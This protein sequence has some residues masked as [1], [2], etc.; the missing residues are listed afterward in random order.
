MK[1]DDIFE[2]ITD[3]DDNL[4]A[5]ALITED[6][7]IARPAYKPLWKTA[8]PIAAC[9]AA[10]V[11]AGVFGARYF[12][13]TELSKI[14]ESSPTE[15]STASSIVLRY[16]DEAKY[17]VD[18][19]IAENT[20]KLTWEYNDSA[21]YDNSSIFAESYEEL[22]KQSDL[23]LS[24]IFIDDTRQTQDPEKNHITGSEPSE[25]YNY[26]R[27]ESVIKGSA[28]LG[29]NVL[30]R[31]KTS[32][33][34]GNGDVYINFSG[35]RLSP[36][37]KGD[38]WI[39][40][41]KKNGEFYEPVN[42]PQ[43][44]YPLSDSTNIT[45]G[46]EGYDEYFTLKNAAPAR[47]EIYNKL[48]TLLSSMIQRIDI[49]ED[50]SET[51]FTMS[52]C[53][54]VFYASKGGIYAAAPSSYGIDRTC[55]METL[56][57]L[58]LY[59]ADINEDG[60]RELC[61]VVNAN[62]AQSIV[63]NQ[64][65]IIE[66]ES[67][68]Y[69]SSKT[70]RILGNKESDYTLE[71]NDGKLYAVKR[72]FQPIWESDPPEEISREQLTFD[73]ITQ[74]Q[75]DAPE[76]IAVPSDGSETKFTLDDGSNIEYAVSKS[77]V[78]ADGKRIIEGE[79]NNLFLAKL[80]KSGA[81]LI[82]A[83]V[84]RNGAGTVEILAD[85]LYRLTG[86]PHDVYETE[87]KS[88][89]LELKDNE[90]NLVTKTSSFDTVSINEEPI[91]L[92]TLNAMTPVSPTE[93][94]D[95]IKLGGGTFA[96]EEYPE[97]MFTCT[98]DSG[99]I[100][101]NVT[102]T[103]P[104]KSV[105]GAGPG[106]GNNALFLKDLNGDG[107]RELCVCGSIGSGIIHP[108]ITVFDAANNEF[109]FKNGAG[110]SD[111]YWREISLEMKNGELYFVTRDYNDNSE[112][113]R[114]L[115][116][117]EDL[118]ISTPKPKYE[119]LCLDIERQ[120]TLDDFPGIFEV[121]HIYNENSTVITLSARSSEYDR[122]FL[123][124]RAYLYD[125]NGDGK[126]ELCM[127]TSYANVPC[128]EVWGLREDGGYGEKIFYDEHGCSLEFSEDMLCLI[129]YGDDLINP[130][131][132]KKS[133]FAEP[134]YTRLPLTNMSA[135]ENIPNE[136]SIEYSENNDFLTIKRANKLDE[137]GN[138]R[139]DFEWNI[140]KPRETYQYEFDGKLLLIVTSVDPNDESGL[141]SQALEL[142]ED[143]FVFNDLGKVSVIPQNGVLVKVDA[144]DI[145]PFD[146]PQSG[147]TIYFD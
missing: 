67:G 33:N 41:L 3:I 1:T 87:T 50:G 52:E 6:S 120:F 15:S 84:T 39:Y 101:E 113:S 60:K 66:T 134:K 129:K 56:Q 119:Q 17:T 29:D 58:D 140:Y 145:K 130:L 80:D 37:F 88:Y 45:P 139:E 126:R 77:G 20:E 7:S 23:I 82:C 69:N 114:E 9:V 25:S 48:K 79:V 121:K 63:V 40:F 106:L 42:G 109:Y 97:L 2:A 104:P 132:V 55:I 74:V 95:E 14:S 38:R 16:P 26:L 72:K 118:E 13:K 28:A 70:F 68:V 92:S 125:V 138:L 147:D 36:M 96:M 21:M 122:E 44:R 98:K 89:S 103:K 59:L 27:A 11:T 83:A 22:A 108:F 85:K 90:L 51:T 24:G 4:I 65:I 136:Y 71:E 18:I 99:V 10:I 76:P 91:Y 54:T 30:I 111:L 105:F 49:P 141:I 86:K 112:L 8:L 61:A 127:D 94:P 115:L 5:S 131:T 144:A 53:D 47:N 31:Q 137:N 64:I 110:T 128:V 12:G 19:N 143:C 133:E 78:F 62:G 46:N 117:L 35:D 124:N 102:N 93:C 34:R 135:P 107:K 73:N 57:L 116:R 81:K 32:L 142:Y 100:F 43:G 123:A 75:I 146:L